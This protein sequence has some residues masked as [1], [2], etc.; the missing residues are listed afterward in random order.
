M[1]VCISTGV[2]EAFAIGRESEIGSILKMFVITRSKLLAAVVSRGIQILA[3]WCAEMD[4]E[5]KV[6]VAFD[7]GN[8]EW[9]PKL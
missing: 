1:N 8:Q 7:W 6:L 3:K 2:V 5:P 9:I 4:E